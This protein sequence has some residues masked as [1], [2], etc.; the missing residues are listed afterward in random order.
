MHIY[1]ITP[2]GMEDVEIN[3]EGKRVEAL[4][5]NSDN[6][7]MF[8]ITGTYG[9]REKP[10]IKGLF[11]LKTGF[12]NTGRFLTEGFEEFSDDFITQGWSDRQKKKAREE[13][14]AEEKKRNRNCTS[15]SCEMSM[16]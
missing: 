15:T 16:C 14:S 12:Q 10:G 13:E 5:I 11:Y 1:H 8:I 9:E 4:H 6:N 3:L 2:E 7:R